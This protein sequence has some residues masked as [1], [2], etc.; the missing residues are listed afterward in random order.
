[1]QGDRAT[2]LK[3]NADGDARE[4]VPPDRRH[5][6]P[7]NSPVRHRARNSF[8]VTTHAATGCER[9]YMFFHGMALAGQDWSRKPGMIFETWLSFLTKDYNPAPFSSPNLAV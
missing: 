6:R 4:N 8:A 2:T 3:S 7:V 1:M 5:A 9:V